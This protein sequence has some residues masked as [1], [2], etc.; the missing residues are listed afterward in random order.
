MVRGIYGNILKDNRFMN[1]GLLAHRER[2]VIEGCRDDV[3]L[4]ENQIML[5]RIGI[6]IEK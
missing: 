1:E 6:F 2:R 4:Y 3:L 5:S